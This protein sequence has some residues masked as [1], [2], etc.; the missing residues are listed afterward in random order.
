MRGRVGWRWGLRRDYKVVVGWLLD[1][2]MVVCWWCCVFIPSNIWIE[3]IDKLRLREVEEKPVV[4]VCYELL[5]HSIYCANP[6]T[7]TLI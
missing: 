1:G 4:V 5:M 2:G 7:H 6:H 3:F